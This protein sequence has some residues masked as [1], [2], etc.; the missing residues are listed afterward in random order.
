MR[1]KDKGQSTPPKHFVH[2][3]SGLLCMILG[4]SQILLG[5]KNACGW[6]FLCEQ[7]GEWI[8]LLGPCN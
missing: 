1:K 3:L 2:F 6:N 5:D 7:I 8:S 4:K